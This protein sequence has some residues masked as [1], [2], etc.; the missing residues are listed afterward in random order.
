MVCTVS[1]VEIKIMKPSQGG[2]YSGGGTQGAVL[3]GWYSGGGTLILS[4]T[5]HDG[6]TLRNF[7]V[8]L[9]VSE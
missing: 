4:I 5:E 1:I 9:R 7:V 2:W 3:R 8:T 6:D